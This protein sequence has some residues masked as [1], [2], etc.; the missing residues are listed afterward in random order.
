MTYRD[1]SDVDFK[2]AKLVPLMPADVL[3]VRDYTEQVQEIAKAEGHKHRYAWEPTPDEERQRQ[4]VGF[5]GEVALAK[6][7]KVPHEFP[8]G[9]DP[10]R[11]DVAGHEVRSTQ[12]FNGCL[13]THDTDKPAI[14]V[15]AL[16]H[17]ISYYKFDVVLAGWIDIADANQP[18][19][20]RTDVRNP[21]YFT[22]QIALHPMG[23]L[24]PLTTKATVGPWHFN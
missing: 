3:K 9:Y 15:L 14:Y 23:M 18:K 21:A 19:H 11:N 20:W 16:V 6:Y 7:L 13:I 17:R 2:R 12:R 5:F 24:Q 10:A 1:Y 22:P 4:L 8:L